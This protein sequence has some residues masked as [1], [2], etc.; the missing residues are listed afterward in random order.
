MSS[1]STSSSPIKTVLLPQTTTATTGAAAAASQRNQQCYIYGIANRGFLDDS[2]LSG[3]FNP[4][5]NSSS[6]PA[7]PPL[8]S[9]HTI[10][11]LRPSALVFDSTGA[12]T[13]TSTIPSSFRPLPK[14]AAPTIPPKPIPTATASTTSTTISESTTTT[15]T[16]PPNRRSSIKTTVTDV[17]SPQLTSPVVATTTAINKPITDEEIDQ[18]NMKKL[19]SDQLTYQV[20]WKPPNDYEALET[21]TV[22]GKAIFILEFKIF[23]EESI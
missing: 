3:F 9:N 13:S 17:K 4:S 1:S 7:A 6:I 21:N 5:S 19:M 11:Q 12:R 15:N 20:P 16:N 14:P 10:E 23:K 8:R 18:I 22:T 2:Q